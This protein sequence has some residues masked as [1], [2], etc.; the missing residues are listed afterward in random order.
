[1]KNSKTTI[2]DISEALGI[3]AVSVSRAL[4]GQPGISEELKSRI[5]QKAKELGYAKSKKASQLNILVLHKKPY[6]EDNSNF[7]YMVQGLE[8]SLQKHNLDY[9]VEF[10]DA[11]AHE[12]LAV[13]YKLSKGITFDG[14]IL[15]G[16]FN[17]EYADFI[18]KKVNNIIYFTGYSPSYDYDCVRY[19]FCNAGYK[20]CAYL[21]KR[22]HTKIG[23][24]GNSRQI[25]N[26]EKLLGITSALADYNLSFNSDYYIESETEYQEKLLDLIKKKKIPSAFICENDFKAVELIRFLN[27][28]N[29][30]VPEDV[31]VIGSGNTDISSLSSPALTTLDLNIGYTS[32]CV[33]ETLLKRISAPDKPYE[34]IMILS[35][36]IERESVSN[37]KT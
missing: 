20:Q 34:S 26:Q 13:P 29:I 33:V 16:R 12:K 35:K 21:L 23:F 17:P 25:K 36:L 8:K 30:K 32:D 6:K 31:S 10:V 4:S 19:N 37:F 14:V 5:L 28:K 3:S 1:M 11:N 22:N 7:S 18:Q 15:V 2:N 24:M 27:S 9:S